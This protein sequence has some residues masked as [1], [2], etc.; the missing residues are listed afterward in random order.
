MDHGEVDP[1][2]CF[3]ERNLFVH[4]KISAL[5]L[6]D[7]VRPYLHNKDDISWLNIWN[8]ISFAMDSKLLAIWRSLVNFDREGLLISLDLLSLANFASFCHVDDF[9]G[10][11]TFVARTCALRVHSWTHLPHDSSHTASLATRTGLDG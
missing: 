6:V 7:L 1:C 10:A 11:T 3:E 2:K 5:S 9:S 8:A 4:V